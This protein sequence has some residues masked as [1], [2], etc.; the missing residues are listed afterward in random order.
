MRGR[1]GGRIPS[2]L[3]IPVNN[4]DRILLVRLSHLGDVVHALGVFH[5]LHGAFPRAEIAWAIQQEFAELVNPLPGLTRLIRFER[6]GGLAAWHRLRRELRDFRAQWS[7]DVQGN[8]KSGAVAWISGADRRSAA[9]VADWQE[10]WAA[11]TANDRAPVLGGPRHAMQLMEHLTRTFVPTSEPSLRRDA[12][13]SAAEIARGEQELANRLATLGRAP[14]LLHLSS[15]R[16]VRGWP[17]ERWRELMRALAAEG[18]GALCLSGP[19]ERELGQHLADEF[20]KGFAHWVDQRGLRLLAAVFH[21]AARR[22]LRLVAC[23][24]GPMHLAAAHGLAV[25]ALVGPEDERRTGPYPLFEPGAPHRAV[26]SA[27][28]LP[29]A[30][31]RKSRCGLSEGPV[32]M[33]DLTAAQVL[34]ATDATR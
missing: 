6:R 4:P 14:L 23:D 15:P 30:P 2:A 13:L 25:V 26:R 31:C 18:R 12:A 24:S 10:P 16:D 32:C 29:C 33:A 19:A 20:Q 11:W 9:G 8:A 5:A 34:A 28:P 7:L 21:A 22:D 17:H 27:R 1:T 3:E